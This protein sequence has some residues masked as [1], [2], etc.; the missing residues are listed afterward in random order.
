[1]QLSEQ[2]R[3]IARV[4]DHTLLKPEATYNQ[5]VQLCHEARQYH[6]AS[7]CVNPSFVRLCADLLR[8]VEDVKVCTVIGF[9]LGATLPEVKAYEAEQAI[10]HG[11]TEIDMVQNVGALKSRDC[12][13]L[14]HDMAA[15]VEVAHRHGALCKVILETALLSDEEKELACGIAKEVGADFVKTSTGFGPG[16]AT[17]SDIA[18]MRRVVG[19]ELGVKASGGVRTYADVRALLD[20]GATRIGASAGVR[21]VE[22]AQGQA[23]AT[24]IIDTY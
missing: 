3:A 7:V 5:I 23:V 17:V 10:R 12:E 2:A 14:Q 15:V 18:L 24:G 1:M 6:F 21:I 22:E 11:A 8:D 19:P 20:A 4:I 9:P 13:T 16:G